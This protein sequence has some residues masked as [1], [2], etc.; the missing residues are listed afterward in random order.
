MV[1]C[2]TTN[3]DELAYVGP[4]IVIFNNTAHPTAIMYSPEP[5]V[6][7]LQD[8]Y[9][10]HYYAFAQDNASALYVNIYEC[11]NDE[12]YKVD[13]NNLSG[14]G[15]I[16]AG[17]NRSSELT[18]ISKLDRT[19]SGRRADVCSYKIEDNGGSYQTAIMYDDFADTAYDPNP[20]YAI[21]K[22]SAMNYTENEFDRILDTLIIGRLVTAT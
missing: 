5:D 7:T 16:I 10:W 13:Y 12:F 21:I 17:K 9:G 1:I 11:P 18:P 6:I 3:A 15:L 2:C 14:L 19:I 22:I 20:S 4:Y 8:G